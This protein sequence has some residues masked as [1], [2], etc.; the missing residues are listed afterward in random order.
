MILEGLL[1]PGTQL[2]DIP[3]S[4]GVSVLANGIQGTF[5]ILRG[6][7]I[8][9]FGRVAEFPA[10]KLETPSLI[11]ILANVTQMKGGTGLLGLHG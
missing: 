11:E 2:L 9:S 6:Q 7:F 8:L 3:S 4:E 1:F 5:P 10:G